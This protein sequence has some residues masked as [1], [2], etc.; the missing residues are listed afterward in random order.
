MDESVRERAR[1]AAAWSAYPAGDFG[2]TALPTPPAQSAR[3]AT[4]SRFWDKATIGPGCWPWTA[5]VDP[6]GRPR[7]SWHGRSA[8]AVRVSWE[9][10]W[11]RPSQFV[12]VQTCGN[13]LC[14]R[15]D[16]LAEDPSRY[17]GRPNSPT[18]PRG[19]SKALHGYLTPDGWLTCRICRREAVARHQ[20][21]TRAA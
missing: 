16:H 13:S 4:E 11:L 12:V 5:C 3:T 10:R 9:L 18:C 6:Q 2:R 20:R 15:P 14:V 1:Q 8:L 7:F 19:H 21:K 17:A